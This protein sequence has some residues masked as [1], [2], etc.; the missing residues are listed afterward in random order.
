MTKQLRAL[1]VED[2]ADDALLLVRELQQGGY[3]V[4][5]RRVDTA[6]AMSEALETQPWDIVYSDYYLPSFS[7]AEALEMAKAHDPDIPFILISG[8]AV[9]TA[10]VAEIMR[11]GARDWVMKSNLARLIPATERELRESA[12]RREHRRA[13]RALRE[14]EA[15]YRSLVEQSPDGIFVTD[16]Q[17]NFLDVNGRGC[18]MLGY[19]RPELLG[20]NVVDIIPPE[21]RESNYMCWEDLSAV[22]PTKA[23]RRLLRKDGTTLSVDVVS[24]VLPDGRVQCIA[25]DVTPSK[26]KEIQIQQQVAFL[27]NVIESLPHPFYVVDANDYTIEIANSAS[28][29]GELGSQSTCYSLTHGQDK[30]CSTDDHFCPLD[31]IKRTKQP[32]VVEHTHLDK[33]GRERNVEVHASPLFDAAGEVSKIIEYCLDITERK[34]AE[35]EIRKLN[36]ELEKRVYARTRELSALYDVMAV[37]NE[38]YPLRTTLERALRRVLRAMVCP[39]GSIYLLED[40]SDALRLAVHQEALISQMAKGDGETSSDELAEWVLA[41][42]EPLV[43]PDA[44]NDLPVTVEGDHEPQHPYIGVP[45]R[46][47]GQTLGVLSVFGQ[48]ERRFGREDVALLSSIADQVGVAVENARLREQ[49]Q[50]AAVL[51]ERQRLARELHDSVTQ[52][53]YSL[54]LFAEG[55]QE[56]AQAEDLDRVKECFAALGETAQQALKEM[57]LLLY[58]LRPVAL[59]QE[60]LIGALQQR[61]DA[62]EA[63]SGVKARLLVDGVDVDDPLS[64]LP[65]SVEEGLYRIAQE[66]LNNALKHAD[67]RAVTVH[68]LRTG[69]HIE[70]EVRDD[71]VGFEPRGAVKK[72]GM[73][74]INMRERA[75]QIGGRLE[76][77]SSPGEG[78]TVRVKVRVRNAVPAEGDR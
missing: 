32:V 13:E 43:L 10:I 69:R 19:S 74:L 47:R 36:E 34:R 67:S 39:A 35:R 17:G 57:R 12:V 11:A 27:N 68:I 37:A 42:G 56:F 48:E 77:V 60:G 46:A 2:S 50:Q 61:L 44:T 38:T 51:E 6:P 40:G 76:V 75:E 16:S 65:L 28:R 25:R 58:E 45:M 49:A 52:S 64:V 66:A 14:S 15:R 29:L 24:R 20:L 55:G 30:P 3:D 63:R 31:I 18:A 8:G 78:T 9:E 33:D 4:T 70:L 21:D 59:E 23:E 62:V 71:G 1:I 53:I 41:R 72:G 22:K 54:T 26:R 73:G 5:Y 7:G